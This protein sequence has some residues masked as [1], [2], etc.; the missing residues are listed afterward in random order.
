VQLGKD[1]TMNRISSRIKG[2]TA[3][4]V[5]LLA[6]AGLAVAQAPA[7]P[8]V[9]R[10]SLRGLSGIRVVVHPLDPAAESAGLQYD[11]FFPLTGVD[12]YGLIDP[13]KHKSSCWF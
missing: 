3:L 2:G 7:G 8:D 13:R 6:A 9:S 10:D 11:S 12:T 1:K 5:A 4:L